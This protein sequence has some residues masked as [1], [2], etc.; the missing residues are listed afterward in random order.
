MIKSAININSEIE[1]EQW[2][3]FW[4]KSIKISVCYTIQENCYKLLYRW[5]MTL[6]KLAKINK[7]LSVHAGNPSKKKDQCIICGGLVNKQKSIGRPFI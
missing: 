1:M 3:H 7:N 6:K 4:R 2:E 5:Y